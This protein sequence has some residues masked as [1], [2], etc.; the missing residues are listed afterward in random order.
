[1][2]DQDSEIVN[3][4]ARAGLRSIFRADSAGAMVD[5]EPHC[6]HCGIVLEARELRPRCDECSADCDDEFCNAFGCAP[7]TATSPAVPRDEAARVDNRAAI[8]LLDEW[9]KQP[10]TEDDSFGDELRRLID[11]N[12]LSDRKF[13]PEA[14]EA[15]VDADRL[16]EALRAECCKSDKAE[17]IVFLSRKKFDKALARLGFD[18]S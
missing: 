10:A 17:L 9:L 11:E 3:R 16:W 14:T 15:A 2:N 13:W 5:N 6:W 7:A 4:M 1:M 12:R 18:N 8:A